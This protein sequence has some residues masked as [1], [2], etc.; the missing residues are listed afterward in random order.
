MPLPELDSKQTENQTQGNE[1]T[2]AEEQTGQSEGQ[3]TEETEKSGQEVLDLDAVPK[4]KF[5]GEEF[6]PEELHKAILRQSDYTKK[7]Q[8]LAEDKK[9][10]SNLDADLAQVKLN[11]DLAEQ[12]RA[13]YPERFHHFVDLVMN[14]AGQTPESGADAD[15]DGD[16][17]S[18]VKALKTQLQQALDEVKSLKAEMKEL[19]G[20]ERSREEQQW[21]EQIEQI[22]APL[23]KEYPLADPIRVMTAVESLHRD[24]YKI[25]PGVW[26]RVFKQAH[27]RTSEISEGLYR[28]R[29]SEQLKRLRENQDMGP[30]G[31]TPGQAPKRYSSFAEATDAAIKHLEKS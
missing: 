7:T 1:Q 30:G 21:D 29:T 5:Q 3:E 24:G 13:I 4:F 16:T 25:T 12:F 11:P 19:S 6:T 18:G 20:K 22:M 2:E 8:A 26:Q 15:E 14:Q 10:L 27:E 23:E 28:Q 31:G 17:D 9:Y